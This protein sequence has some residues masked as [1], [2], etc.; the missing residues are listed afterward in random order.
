MGEI[1]RPSQTM[2]RVLQRAPGA[3]IRVPRIQVLHSTPD[4][5]LIEF[6]AVP[7]KIGVTHPNTTV[8]PRVALRPRDDR[9]I[10]VTGPGV[11]SRPDLRRGEP[12]VYLWLIASREFPLV[13]EQDIRDVLAVGP[14]R[15]PADVPPGGF[16]IVV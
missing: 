16:S 2:D 1:I 11:G 6:A 4:S 7:G 5:K 10:K 8:Q 14:R 3:V 12:T 15:F 13:Q 9:N